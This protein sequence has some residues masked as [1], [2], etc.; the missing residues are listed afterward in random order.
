[1]AED[2]DEAIPESTTLRLAAV[3]NAAFGLAHR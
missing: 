2:P 3:V 1:M